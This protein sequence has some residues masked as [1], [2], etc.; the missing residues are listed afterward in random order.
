MTKQQL[1]NKYKIAIVENGYYRS[2]GGYTKLYDVYTADGCR[3]G[4]GFRTIKSVETECKK[5]EKA[6]LTIA[7]NVSKRRC[8]A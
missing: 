8:Y 2:T 4:A 5:W 1:E 7:E 3:W 6:I